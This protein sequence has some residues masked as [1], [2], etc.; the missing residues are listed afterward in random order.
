MSTARAALFVLLV[1]CSSRKADPPAQLCVPA[2]GSPYAVISNGQA[3]VCVEPTCLI[4]DRDGKP[5]GTTTST[6]PRPPPQVQQD[7]QVGADRVAARDP[8]GQWS[9]KNTETGAVI[10]VGKPGDRL[11]VAETAVVAY[12]G[13]TLHLA[14]PVTLQVTGTYTM[15]GTVVMVSP[16]FDRVLVVLEKPVGTMQL[17]PATATVYSGP[18]LPVCR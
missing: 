8:S 14:N 17:D 15:P 5:T 7:R 3:I 2:Q 11:D 18:P 10:P 4:L 16:W 1:G 12:Q 9:L 13:N 6:P